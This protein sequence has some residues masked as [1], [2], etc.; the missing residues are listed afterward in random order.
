MNFEE[1]HHNGSGFDTFKTSFGNAEGGIYYGIDKV[2]STPIVE[3]HF[4]ENGLGDLYFYSMKK[5]SDKV[6]QVR[7]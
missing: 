6:A 2:I 5:F 3:E 4:N 1:V 7:L